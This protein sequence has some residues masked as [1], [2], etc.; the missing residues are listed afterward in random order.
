MCCF[1][2]ERKAVILACSFYDIAE[3]IQWVNETKVSQ[4]GKS[5][6]CLWNE[7]TA[8]LPFTELTTSSDETK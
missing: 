3:P 5:I 1:V 2:R 6:L 4:A 7:E 8:K